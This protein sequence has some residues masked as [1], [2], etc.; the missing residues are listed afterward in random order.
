MPKE[1]PTKVY[2]KRHGWRVM[3]TKPGSPTSEIGN[4]IDK[5]EASSFAKE[6]AHKLADQLG[7]TVEIHTEDGQGRPSSVSY[8][9]PTPTPKLEKGGDE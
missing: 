9:N 1:A 6:T 4:R 2:I 7:E 8:V 3:V 5:A